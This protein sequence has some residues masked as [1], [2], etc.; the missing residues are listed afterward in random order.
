MNEKTKICI[1][2]KEEKLAEDFWLEAKNSDGRSAWCR[3][4]AQLADKSGGRRKLLQEQPFPEEKPCVKCGEIKKLED[5]PKAK[6]TKYGRHSYCKICKARHKKEW[7]QKNAKSHKESWQKYNAQPEVKARTK[8]YKTAYRKTQKCK[9]AVNAKR[10]EYRK[11]PTDYRTIKHNMSKAIQRA[12]KG[13]GGTK[14]GSTVEILGL[15]IQEFKRYFETK[16]DKTMSWENRASF[17]IDHIVPVAVFD[18]DNP[19]EEKIAWHHTNLQPLSPDDNI[20]K[21]DTLP[22]DYNHEVYIL[23]KTAEFN[24]NS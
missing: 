13:Q 19:I 10:R 23:E 20:S 5:F 22:T 16:F 17:H 3:P 1:Y 4:C 12:V 8:V 21:A 18:L 24:L 11:D 15:S 14:K 2:C 6:R 9:D 7:R